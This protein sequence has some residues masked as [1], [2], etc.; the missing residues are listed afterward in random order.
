MSR[1][2]TSD[3]E[4]MNATPAAAINSEDWRSFFLGYSDIVLV[5]NSDEVDID[6]L[7]SRFPE[8]TLFVFFNKVYKVLSEPFTRA[9]VLVS[10]SGAQGANLVKSG[11]V[12]KVLPYFDKGSFLGIINLTIGGSERPSPASAFGDVKVRHLDLTDVFAPFYPPTSLPTSGFALCFWL[13]NLQLGVRVTL[14]GFSSKRSERYQVFDVHDWTFEQVVLRLM[15]RRGKI[16][17]LG[18]ER[19]NPY[20]ELSAHFP[21][22][23]PTEIAFT[24]NEVLGERLVNLSSIV[25]RLMHVTRFLRFVDR[26]YKK[27]KPKT[28]KEKRWEAM[29]GK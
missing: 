1:S 20:A 29:E 9:A 2:D 10:R 23:S 22:Y 27:L 19:T 3:L 5:A 13:A 18:R 26:T 4:A 28:R 24:A 8:T 11:K 12:S 14:A 25:D 15:Y 16:D 6:E 7:T 17:I 21:E